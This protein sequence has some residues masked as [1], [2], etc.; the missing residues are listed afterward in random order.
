MEKKT[1]KKVTTKKATTAKK[2][3]SKKKNAKLPVLA[4]ET[5]PFVSNLVVETKTSLLDKIKKLFGF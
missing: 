5:T 1:T 2:P 4:P 3:T